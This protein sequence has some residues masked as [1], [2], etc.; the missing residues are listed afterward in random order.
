[1]LK[2]KPHPSESDP[3][4]APEDEHAYEGAWYRSLKFRANRRAKD[5]AEEPGQDEP[6]APSDE[7]PVAG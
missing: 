3:D 5:G 4:S 2:K 7:G 1:M 6:E